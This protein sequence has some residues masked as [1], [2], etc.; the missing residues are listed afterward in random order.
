M[1]ENKISEFINQILYMAPQAY[2]MIKGSSRYPDVHGIV[3]FYKADKGTLILTEVWGLPHAA[4]NCSGRF[5]GFHIH[6]GESCE[7][8][9]GEDLFAGTGG[10]YN[11]KGCMH[12]E[13]AGDLPPLLGNQGFAWAAC[14]TERFM[15]EEIRNRTVVIHDMPDD[16]KSQPA[17]NAG[18]KIACGRIAEY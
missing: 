3:Y 9:S 1:Y 2:A 11:P 16:F 4:G 7:E 18:E 15:P 6:E 5:F 12:P 17:G 8:T 13:H 14:Y 10:H